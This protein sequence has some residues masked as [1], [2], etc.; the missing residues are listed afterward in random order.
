MRQFL[1]LVCSLIS[2]T[3]ANGVSMYIILAVVA[4]LCL[5]CPAWA[6]YMSSAASSGGGVTQIT[7]GTGITLSPAGGTGVV[8][9]TA[10]GGSTSPQLGFTSAFAP[11][12]DQVG[13]VDG[14][15]NVYTVTS[16][17][18]L[19]KY[20]SSGTVISNTSLTANLS[21]G[22]LGAIIGTDG[23]LYVSGF[24]S[25]ASNSVVLKIKVSDGSNTVTSITVG[26]IGSHQATQLCNGNDSNVWFTD[27]GD[28]A[29]NFYIGKINI[30]TNA[31][32]TYLLTTTHVPAG[33]TLGTD[34]NIWWYGAGTASPLYYGKITT[35]GSITEYSITGCKAISTSGLYNS[36]IC[37][38]TNESTI[39]LGA[40]G[41]G[42]PYAVSHN[43]VLQI[44]PAT[45]AIAVTQD[46]GLNTAS[47]LGSVGYW[48]IYGSDGY[49][50]MPLQG[51]AYLSL[52]RSNATTKAVLPNVTYMLSTAPSLMAWTISKGIQMIA[53]PN[54]L[55]GT[56][57]NSVTT[58]NLH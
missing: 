13:A 14:T 40:V 42:A 18:H 26:A 15:G 29:S 27:Q 34:N 9:V 16:G 25:A 4:A 55:N 30:N 21:T 1:A 6:D 52:C 7:A 47:A 31:V 57:T 46:Y 48:A 12:A 10:S 28:S 56:A 20:S 45:G 11:N 39:Y 23:Y 36:A 38:N 19:I 8:Q 51:T 17:Y 44:T 53:Q 50:Y 2:V 33:I 58:V 22:V 54:Y 41:T 32:T 35:A 49:V 5:V 3:A 37:A 24:D 43:Y